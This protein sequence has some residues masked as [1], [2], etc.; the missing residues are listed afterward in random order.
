MGCSLI[1]LEYKDEGRDA[2]VVS[3]EIRLPDIRGAVYDVSLKCSGPEEDEV[4]NPILRLG[5]GQG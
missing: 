1:R 3:K 2:K 4:H 5:H